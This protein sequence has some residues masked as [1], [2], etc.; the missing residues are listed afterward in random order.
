MPISTKVPHKMSAP[1][2]QPQPSGSLKRALE[3]VVVKDT[4]ATKRVRAAIRKL[5]FAR[6]EEIEQLQAE[7]EVI[8][9]EEQAALDDAAEVIQQEVEDVMALVAPR[10]AAFHDFAAKSERERILARPLAQEVSEPAEEEQPVEA[11]ND[12]PQSSVEE[13]EFQEPSVD[14]VHEEAVNETEVEQAAD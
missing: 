11:A 7:L 4:P 14:E 13:P 8:S 10:L 2:Q 6:D 3:A 5:R 9:I 12:T 1:K